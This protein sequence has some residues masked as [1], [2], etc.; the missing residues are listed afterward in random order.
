MATRKPALTSVLQRAGSTLPTSLP[1]PVFWFSA[2]QRIQISRSS[3]S[4]ADR[5]SATAAHVF[6]WE[7]KK[8][9]SRSSEL[10]EEEKKFPY[11]FLRW[12]ST[13]LASRPSWSRSTS[14]ALNRTSSRRLLLVHRGQ[15]DFK[16]PQRR[17]FYVVLH[18]PIDFVGAA[19]RH[20]ADFVFYSLV[21]LKMSSPT[22]T[23]P[24]MNGEE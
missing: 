23:T 18:R 13:L 2:L 11:F 19:S 17:P 10:E 16:M 1:S 21:L 6:F 3:A 14:R 7:K 5:F 8:N 24:F 12:A 20:S 15:G 9:N 4:P 22:S